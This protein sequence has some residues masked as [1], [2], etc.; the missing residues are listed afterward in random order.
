ME[1]LRKFYA[2]L[3][4]KKLILS[5]LLILMVGISAFLTLGITCIGTCYTVSSCDKCTGLL[6]TCNPSN[7][8]LGK[9]ICCKHKD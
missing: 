5:F 2:N 9:Y 6:S 3:E 8:Y 1:R 4:I 7:T